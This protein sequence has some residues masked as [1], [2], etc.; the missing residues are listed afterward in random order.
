MLPGPWHAEAQ[1]LN[2]ARK[3]DRVAKLEWILPARTS[4]GLRPLDMEV[5]VDPFQF[6][7]SN[8]RELTAN[9]LAKRIS[10]LVDGKAT[11]V[12]SSEHDSWIDISE[13]KKS[14]ARGYND[15]VASHTRVP[16]LVKALDEHG[17]PA[18][19]GKQ[20][21]LMFRPVIQTLMSLLWLLASPHNKTAALAVRSAIVGMNDSGK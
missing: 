5:A 7:S 14:Q 19:A 1:D 15:P 9:L 2:P 11:R 18:V 21:L 8:D 4:S 12:Y 13:P 10:A 20:G 16:L 3:S 6:D 17:V